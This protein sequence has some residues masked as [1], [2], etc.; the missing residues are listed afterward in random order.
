MLELFG[1][2]TYP[3][4][5]DM[6]DNALT[7]VQM[8][9]DMD[10]IRLLAADNIEYPPD[11]KPGSASWQRWAIE[12]TAESVAHGRFQGKKVITALPAGEVFIETIKMPEAPEGE[13]HNAILNHLKP[14]LKINPDEVLMEH[15]K[16]DSENIL[17]MATD[18]TKLYRHLA[19]YEKARLKVVSISVWPMAVLRAYTHLWARHMGQDDKPVMLLSIGKS[20][21]N[22]V[23]CDSVNL[24]FAHTAP[25]GAKN[26]EIDRMV[27]LLGSEMDMCR[28]RFRSTHKRPQVNH[29]IFVS[30]HA[31]DN[32]IYT[33]IAKWAHM[34]AQ[35]GDCFDAVGATRP[36]QPGPE[37]HAQHANWITAMGLSL[38]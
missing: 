36:D 9:N 19:I 18:K 17:V 26:L 20:C 2:H 16:T 38:S 24:Y 3:I 11:I 33:K 5:V 21:T 30:G 32:D 12:A 13:L 14:K 25:V 34:S 8:T 35:I 7:L 27:D 28:V 31:V 29:I 15:V 37:N 4:G 22:I 23:I 6:G 10:A 1:N